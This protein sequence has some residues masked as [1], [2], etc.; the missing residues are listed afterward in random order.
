MESE[1]IRNLDERLENYADFVAE[2]R[3]CLYFREASNTADYFVS[4]NIGRK[5]E[6]KFFD[7]KKDDKFK[8]PLILSTELMKPNVWIDRELYFYLSE[9][10]EGE[11]EKKH[12]KEFLEMVFSRQ[13]DKAIN[14]ANSPYRSYN[15]ARFARRYKIMEGLGTLYL[16]QS[17]NT[18]IIRG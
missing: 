6:G 10:L 14:P 4:E 11:F 17:P 8:N 1:L 16:M 3:Q 2:N 7:R 15:D 5:R 18:T 9:A 13:V 12:L